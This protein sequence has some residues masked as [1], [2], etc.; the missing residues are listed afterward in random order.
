[1]FN[2]ILYRIGQ[3]LA[4]SLPIKIAYAVAVFCSD[5]HQIFA[6]KDRANVTANLKVIFPDKP[7]NEIRRIRLKM[8]RNFAKYLVDFFR[9]SLIDKK[10]MRKMVK[11]ENTHYLD[12][13]LARKK[14]VIALSAH[15][16]NWELGGAAVALLGYDIW[17]V[18]LKHKH[19]IVNDFFN[20]QRGIKGLK[21]IPLGK[22]VRKCLEVFGQNGI[23]ALVGDRDFS[24]KGAVIDL[25]GK[26][27]ILPEGPAA[28]HLKVGAPIVPVFMV[29]N[30]DDTFTL[31]IDK[32]IE[33]KPS[34][35]KNKDLPE[36]MSKYNITLEHYI[37]KYPD[38]WYMFRKFWI[39]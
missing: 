35:N 10:Y 38:Q 6:D 31:I 5:L 26:P 27:A 1:M 29:R 25:F 14:G 13:A 12:E 20:K 7:L 11:L 15:L 18:A 9:F 36:L 39:K 21:V 23:I 34:G 3:F 33:F 2:Y 8:A 37:K 4:L 22:A 24:E 32:P 17:A 30:P 19:K 16:G 28:F